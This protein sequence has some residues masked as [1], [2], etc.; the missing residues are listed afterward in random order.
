[1]P[2]KNNY[3]ALSN[4]IVRVPA[5]PKNLIVNLLIKPTVETKDLLELINDDQ[6]IEAL[7]LAAPEFFNEVKAHTSKESIYNEKIKQSLIK[8]FIRMSTR[9]TP[10]GLFA[11]CSAIGFGESTSIIYSQKNKRKTRFD[12]TFIL[13]VIQELLKTSELK[14]HINWFPNSS[15]YAVGN[16]LRYIQYET[17][18]NRR[19]YKIEGVKNNLYLREILEI[20]KNGKKLPSLLKHLT[21]KGFLENES[22]SFIDTLI[23]NQILVSELEPSLVGTSLKDKLF[24]LSEVHDKNSVYS[25]L[26]ALDIK[27]KE[28]DNAEIPNQPSS[29]IKIKD[30]IKKL[31]LPTTKH[32]FQTD[33]F[34]DL[35]NATIN[36]KW[37]YKLKKLIPFLYRISHAKENPHIKKFKDEFIKRYESKELPLVEILDVEMGIG[38]P[39]HKANSNETYIIDEVKF[40]Y[41][42]QEKNEL[43]LWND[44]IETLNQKLQDRWNKNSLIL[45]LYDADFEHIDSSF[46][47][48]LPDTIYALTEL[49]TINN[50]EKMFVNIFGGSSAANLISR[51][52][53]GDSGI[54][55]IINEITNIEA[56]LNKEK[57]IAEIIHLPEERTGNV[58]HRPENIRSYEIPYLAHSN[59]SK[60][61]QI[62]IDDIMISIRNDCVILRSKRLNQEIN[63]MLTNAHNYS[64]S[65]LPIYRFLCDINLQKKI[66]D[67][68]FHWG[69]LSK[70]YRFL[71]RVVYKDFI[72]S[73]ARWT[74]KT[75]EI[76]ILASE[77][78]DDE[79]LIKTFSAWRTKYNI[80]EWI[81][82]VEGDNTLALNL[83]NV[84]CIYT[85]LHA[86]S[87]KEYVELEECF[88]R[89]HESIKNSANEC[90]ANQM[91]FSF[92]KVK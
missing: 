13:K 25:E 75:K 26:K 86:I 21:N 91:I 41:G 57:I 58:L 15:L 92:Y 7:F 70:I 74:F 78:R 87:T 88:L 2:T 35:P 73:K 17:H 84:D 48:N 72:L 63:P 30:E 40:T 49:L 36:Q 64:T 76:T 55:R 23:D 12:S 43:F 33:L 32:L 1:M 10:F 31:S 67:I 37:K 51:F 85:L 50:I 77:L 8:Y 29:Y 56:N 24:E 9:C 22:Q 83:K 11:G 46:D 79:E 52:H 81:Q 82:L 68:S 80:P 14:N 4:I 5:F 61:F 69:C 39:V 38:Y 90:Y 71:P 44:I 54:R 53:Y 3:N 89:Y 65:T 60:E 34:I 20:S 27:L 59:K 28:L 19:N 47:D 45:E 66:G 6:V 62:P 42:K 16:Q 18:L